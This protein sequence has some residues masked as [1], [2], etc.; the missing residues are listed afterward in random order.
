MLRDIESYVEFQLSAL[1]KLDPSVRVL[2]PCIH[3]CCVCYVRVFVCVVCALSVYSSVLCLYGCITDILSPLT[4]RSKHATETRVYKFV[5]M[6]I[7]DPCSVR[8]FAPR[9]FVR[10]C[11]CRVIGCS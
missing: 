8:V 7:T 5:L 2:C 3:V 1:S 9:W 6:C 4:L 11:V 10:V